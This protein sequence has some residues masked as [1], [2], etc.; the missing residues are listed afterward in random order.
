MNPETTR[1]PALD[2]AALSWAQR[3]V[4]AV[5]VAIYLTVFIGGISAGGAELMTLGR[6]IGFTLAAA[7]LGRIALRLLS[8]ASLPVE[9]GPSANQAGPVG[10]R[11]DLVSSA[12]FAAQEDEA[13]AA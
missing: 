12:N 8:K 7:V 11:V 13:E 9:E 2:D 1:K 5:C 10:S 3:V 4:W 6:A